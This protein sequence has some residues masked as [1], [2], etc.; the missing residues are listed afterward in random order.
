MSLCRPNRVHPQRRYVIS[1]FKM[2]VTAAQFYFSCR[3]WCN[4]ALNSQQLWASGR[5]C[6]P[7]LM[8]FGG[9][10]QIRTSMTVTDQILKFL[11][12][13]MADGR[14]VGKYWKCLN[15]PINGPIWTKLGWSHP[16]IS[17]TCS[18]CC[19]CHGNG[20]CLVTAVA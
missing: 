20:R 17:P 19:G 15:L 11:Q 6:E 18:P 13:K 4:G 2:A 14:H 5:T 8:K 3:I 16:I 9:Q 7:I 12:L 1:I 10:Q